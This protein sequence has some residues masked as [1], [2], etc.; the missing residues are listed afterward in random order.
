VRLNYEEEYKKRI[1]RNLLD[2]LNDLKTKSMQIKIASWADKFGYSHEEIE[3]KI[4]N[5]EIFRC[6]FAKDPAKQNLYQTL[7]STYIKSLDAVK[8]FKILPSGGKD[9]IYLISGKKFFGKDLENKSKNI[10]SIDFQWNTG[11][12]VF[13]ASHKYTKETGGAQDNQYIDVQNFLRS[14]I[15]CNEKNTIFIAICD[16]RYYLEKDASTG[17][18]TKIDR[19]RRLTDNRTSFVMTIDDLKDFLQKYLSI[20]RI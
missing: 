11:K 17:D 12:F 7:A 10:K 9:A 6:V 8:N 15:D 13:Y 14:T 2:I 5:D 18:T 3:D 20:R 16:G 4:K 19:L 1:K